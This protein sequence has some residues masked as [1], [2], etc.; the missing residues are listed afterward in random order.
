MSTEPT[1]QVPP[2]QPPASEWGATPP[3]AAP[4]RKWNMKRTVIAV[5]VAVGIAGAGGAAI[6]AASGSVASD[7]RNGPGAG[8]GPMMISGPGGGFEETQHGEFQV[9]E[10][11]AVSDKSITAKSEDGYTQTYVVDSDTVLDG[12]EKGDSVTIVATMSGDTATAESVME[13]GAGMSQRRDGGNGAPPQGGPQG[14]TDD[15]T[16]G[17]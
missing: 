6:Y 9:G 7:Q 11:T 17:N 2:A 3:P 1:E 12:I 8:G 5:V 4:N 13:R 16:D 10:V 14:N 15:D